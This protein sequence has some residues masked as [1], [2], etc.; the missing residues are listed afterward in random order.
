MTLETRHFIDYINRLNEQYST[1]RAREHSYRPAL[2]I[3]MSE[4]IP[5]AIV[6]NE[7]ARIAC[8]APDYILTKKKDSLPF[9][10]IEAKDLNDPDLEGV[11][12]NKE[13]FDRYKSS[14]NNI[15]F[16][17]YL[18]FIFYKDG[19]LIFDIRIAECDKNNILLC[20]DKIVAFSRYVED[21]W[22]WSPQAV[23][24]SNILAEQMAKKAR[25]LATIIK[26]AFK[27]ADSLED[28]SNAE[29]LHDWLTGFREI[30]IHD[31]TADEFAD[32]YAQTVTYGL[33]A[34]RLN[35]PTLHSFSRFEAAQLIPQTTPFL[36]KVF[37]NIAGNDLDNRISWVIDDLAECF[38]RS[39]LKKIIKRDNDSLVHFYEDFLAAYDPELRKAKGVWYT[40]KEVVNF[41]VRGIDYILKNDFAISN[42]IADFSKVK[43]D[44]AITQSYDG[45]TKDRKKH[46]L[47]DFH[48][49]QILDP[50]V[51]TGTFLAEIFHQIHEQLK[52]QEGLW[53]S[54]VENH[55][56]PRVA[57][58]EILMASYAIAHVKLDLVLKQTGYVPTKKQERLQVYL[59]N[60]LEESH[61]DTDTLFARWLSDEAN[62]ANRIKRDMPVLVLIGNPPYNGSSRNTGNWIMNLLDD[63]KKEPGTR[64]PLKEKNPK[65]INN[66]YVK[67]IR[68]AQYY[69][70][71]NKEGL[72]AYIN[73]HGYLDN[74]TFRG[75]RYNL[76]QAFDKI[77][78]IDLHGSVKKKEKLQDGSFDEN[79]FDIQ[80]GVSIN[81]F[82]KTSNKKEMA[83]VYFGDI[84]GKREE[85]YNTLLNSSLSDIS[86]EEIK[87]IPPYYSF[88][89][90]KKEHLIDWNKNI[91]LP[92][93]FI[94]STVG[95]FTGKDDFVICKTKDEAFTKIQD[96]INLN[97]AEFNKKYQLS[98]AKSWT[99]QKSKLD[100]G[101]SPTQ[102]KIIKISY[103]PFDNKYVYFTGKSNAYMQRPRGKL[104][105]Q[106]LTNPS[107]RAL[108]VGR[109]GQVCGKTEW[110]LAFCTNK[111]IDLN[112]FYRGGGTYFPGG[113]YVTDVQG[114]QNYIS[115]LSKDTIKQFKQNLKNEYS[116]NEI[117]DYIYAILYSRKYRKQFSEFLKTEYPKIPIPRSDVEFQR[118]KT[119]GAVLYKLHTSGIG[120]EE[121]ETTFPVSGSNFVSDF[122]FNQTR[123]YINNKQYISNVSEEVWNFNIGGYQVIYKW[124]KD[125]NNSNLDFND[126]IQLQKICTIISMTIKEMQIID[127][128]FI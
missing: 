87:P 105:N 56:I 50:A 122:H 49:V 73:P 100:I 2:Q 19:N 7:P 107:P 21:F 10:F 23:S 92:D 59:T 108:I 18:R 79:V 13:Q 14:L 17:D 112:I 20:T 125:R 44:I 34:A 126:I 3:L 32:I 58:F 116:D 110:N 115:N 128:I 113:F 37:Q 52:S 96:L 118:L 120:I 51:G 82:I 15:I 35:D 26:N 43:K 68:L 25:L 84:S 74:P 114:N 55:L 77:I 33:F 36:R 57:G 101:S 47:K 6:T 66:D 106:C 62:E 1:G 42:G 86:F 95:L 121:I 39:N 109:Q 28:E 5:D 78:S 60:S 67:F 27:N 83:K 30:L 71:N 46:I 4:L 81:F 16:T 80:E 98:T 24:S 9:G 104:F 40:P 31:L 88:R 69:I 29:I 75:M 63:Y 8:G 127:Q 64:E 12:K 76:L 48:K 61:P 91:S 99:V 38:K 97:E 119:S 124:L 102:N 111:I 93:F 72:I 89:P 54:Y 103:R 53:S 123:V 41:M 94:K 90:M 70:E 85:K 22:N 45:R 65:W 117:L 11:S